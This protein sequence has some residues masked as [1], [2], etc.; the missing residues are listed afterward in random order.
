MHTAFVML[1]ILGVQIFFVAATGTIK[2]ISSRSMVRLR[3]WSK[4]VRTG[5]IAGE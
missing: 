1:A 5:N 2:D 4:P 3:K